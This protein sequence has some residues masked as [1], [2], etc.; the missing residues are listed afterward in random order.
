MGCAE[1]V[2]AEGL[3]APTSPALDGAASHNITHPDELTLKFHVVHKGSECCV[4]PFDVLTSKVAKLPKGTMVAEGFTGTK[5]S[6]GKQVSCCHGIMSTPL[7]PETMP[8]L[9][10][11]FLEM[12]E[13][14]NMFVIGF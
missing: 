2:C 3:I 6:N 14:R 12:V 4:L 7:F 5:K 13:Q 10:S 1:L 9:P 8:A 11:F